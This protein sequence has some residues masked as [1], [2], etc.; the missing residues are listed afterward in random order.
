LGI[1]E[2][3]ILASHSPLTEDPLCVREGETVGDGPRKERSAG[4][5]TLG[6]A[7]LVVEASGE[8]G[9]RKPPDVDILELGINFVDIEREGLS[10]D[11]DGVS[12]REEQD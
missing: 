7:A 11:L 9:R 8:S 10:A 1:G 6:V 3:F 4:Q 12:A 5:S 2:D